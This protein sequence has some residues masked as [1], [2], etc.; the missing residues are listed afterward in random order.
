M[1]YTDQ[2]RERRVRD[3]ELDKIL[4]EASKRKNKLLVPIIKFACI[5]GMRRSEILNITWNNIDFRERELTISKSKNGHSR[6][7]PLLAEMISILEE[8]DPTDDR[9]F[10][11]SEANFKSTWKRILAK[12]GI[13]DF[14]FHDY[15]H[16][17]LSSLFEKG[18]EIPEVASISGHKTW[19]CLSRYTS[20]QPKHILN[21]LERVAA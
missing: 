5:S 20:I 6:K 12:T 18:L 2:R 14:H 19:K 17:A 11:I 8:L 21:K 1:K 10:P 13:E 15:R 3:G 9:V 16:E 7:I 4:A